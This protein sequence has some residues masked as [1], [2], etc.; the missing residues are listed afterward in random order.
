M[1]KKYAWGQHNQFMKYMIKIHNMFTMYIKVVKYDQG[2]KAY[3]IWS[4]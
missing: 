1:Y 3:K 4:R 2:T